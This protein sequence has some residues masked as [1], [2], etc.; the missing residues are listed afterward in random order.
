VD[1]ITHR[2]FCGDGEFDVKGFVRTML[3]AG[4]DGPWGTEVLDIEWR[5]KP[6]N[7][8]VAKAYSST[9]AQFP[10]HGRTSTAETRRT[11]KK[12][13]DKKVRPKPPKA[14]ASKRKPAKKS[15]ARKRRK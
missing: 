6:L 11:Q 15:K 14:K 2:T 13:K 9:I 8:V 7:E 10:G 12:T 3:K 1:V 5:K 4:Y